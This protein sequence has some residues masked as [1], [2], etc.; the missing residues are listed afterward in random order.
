MCVWVITYHGLAA[1]INPCHFSAFGRVLCQLLLLVIPAMLVT[2]SRGVWLQ[3]S[4]LQRSVGDMIGSRMHTDKRK[5][6]LLKD[7]RVSA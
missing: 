7:S 5:A 1:G 3:P 4:Q 6:Q 2:I